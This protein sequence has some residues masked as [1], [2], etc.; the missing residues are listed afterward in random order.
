MRFNH[1]VKRRIEIILDPFTQMEYM[2]RFYTSEN[3]D[4]EHANQTY[5]EVFMNSDNI[6]KIQILDVIDHTLLG[7]PALEIMDFQV[8]FNYIYLLVKDSGLY[9]FELTP[10]QRLQRRS[11][12]PIKMNVNRFFV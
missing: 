7:L 6:M 4:R 1:L 2:F 9:Q 3:V 12:F 5:V 11:F 8:H 10:T